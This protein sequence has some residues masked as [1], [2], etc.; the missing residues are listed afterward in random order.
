MFKKVMLVLLVLIVLFSLPTLAS[1]NGEESANDKCPDVVC[2]LAKS[3]DA[4]GNL[5]GSGDDADFLKILSALS[6]K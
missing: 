6:A 5:N 2:L 3:I 1:G 4:A